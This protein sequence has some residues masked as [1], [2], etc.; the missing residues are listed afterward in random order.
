MNLPDRG[1]NLRW[2][3]RHLD[4][5]TRARISHFA[6][7]EVPFDHLCWPSGTSLERNTPRR[8]SLT[9]FSPTLRLSKTIAEDARTETCG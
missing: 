4:D 7:S 5:G 6:R 1:I 2:A 8:T 9:L 3:T